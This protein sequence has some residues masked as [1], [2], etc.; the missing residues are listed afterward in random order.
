MIDFEQDCDD[1]DFG[2]DAEDFDFV[3]S[4]LEVAEGDFEGW[5]ENKMCGSEPDIISSDPEVDAERVAW[6]DEAAEA[7]AERQFF[8]SH[9]ELNP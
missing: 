5:L 8:K 6:I 4:I 1:S 3:D 9:P 7:E 2:P